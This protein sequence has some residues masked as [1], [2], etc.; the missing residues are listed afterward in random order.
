MVKEKYFWDS[1]KNNGKEFNS[2]I[3]IKEISSNNSC[4]IILSIISDFNIDYKQKFSDLTVKNNL[5]EINILT[6][7]WIVKWVTKTSFEPD[8]ENNKSRIF[9]YFITNSLLWC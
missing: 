4:P 7:L 2:E 5:S 3:K 1:L 6:K 9:E 8:R